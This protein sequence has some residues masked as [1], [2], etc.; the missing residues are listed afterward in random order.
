MGFAFL[1]RQIHFTTATVARDN[2]NLEPEPF[3]N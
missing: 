2:I 3:L 1:D